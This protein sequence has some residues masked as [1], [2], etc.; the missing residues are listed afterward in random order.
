M[1]TKYNVHLKLTNSMLGTNP[2]NPNV[3][4]NHII[5]RQRKL[6]LE[7]SKLNREINKYAD[8]LGID[9]DKEHQELNKAIVNLEKMLGSPISEEKKKEIFEGKIDSLKET[10]KELEAKGTTVFYRDEIDM[11]CI[12]D[13][14]IYGFLK[15]ASEAISRTLPKKKGTMFH[16]ASYTSSVLNQH[17]RLAEKFISF[18]KDLDR[19]EDNNPRLLERS[20]RAMTAQGPR[21]SLARSEVMLS[22]ASLKFQIQVLENSPLDELG[23]KRLLSYGEMKGLGQWRNAGYG[24]FIYEIFKQK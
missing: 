11:P 9:E 18:D 4:K 20:L 15:A 24:T 5:D 8:Q 3:L 10:F 1:I 16:S 2:I 13:H 12:G 22:G 6:I 19:D 17:V 21:I 7:R 23:L 14:M